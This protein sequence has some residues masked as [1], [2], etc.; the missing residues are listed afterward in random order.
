MEKNRTVEPDDNPYDGHTEEN[1]DGNDGT[2]LGT[3]LMERPNIPDETEMTLFIRCWGRTTDVTVRGC[4]PCGQTT[5]AVICTTTAVAYGRHMII[6][7][8]AAERAG[9]G[10]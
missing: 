2:E 1:L 8:T 7:D 10:A 5:A 3:L 9:D 4:L 6:Y